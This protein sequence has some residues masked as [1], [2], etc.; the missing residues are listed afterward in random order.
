MKVCEAN[1]LIEKIDNEVKNLQKLNTLSPE[2]REEL[3]EQIG[4]NTPVENMVNIS[5]NAMLSWKSILKQK[6][7]NAELNWDLVGKWGK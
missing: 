6:I 3:A 5:V 4:L 7:D 1:K 2:E